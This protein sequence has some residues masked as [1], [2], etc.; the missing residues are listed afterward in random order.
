MIRNS[1]AAEITTVCATI[2]CWIK[3][4]NKAILMDMELQRKTYERNSSQGSNLQKCHTLYLVTV[5]LIF[6]F[7]LFYRQNNRLFPFFF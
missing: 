3:D 7:Q 1:C 5:F 2:Q 4:G 6:L